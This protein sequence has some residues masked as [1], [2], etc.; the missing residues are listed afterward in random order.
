MPV[1]SERRDSLAGTQLHSKIEDIAVSA[2]TIPTDFPESDGTI[3][4]DKT[5]IVVVEV[6]SDGERGLGYTYADLSTAD[7]IRSKLSDE[8]RGKNAM[9]IG[10]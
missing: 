10:R 8:I 9:D 2:Y 1:Q 7:L 3:A 6:S 4:W 5:T